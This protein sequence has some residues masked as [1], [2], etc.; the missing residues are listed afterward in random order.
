MVGCHCVDQKIHIASDAQTYLSHESM[1]IDRIEQ[2]LAIG[3]PDLIAS[4]QHVE[5]FPCSHTLAALCNGQEKCSV[6]IWRYGRHT[7][8]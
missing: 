3:K 7:N 2:P 1:E 8:C 6:L 4:A 5:I